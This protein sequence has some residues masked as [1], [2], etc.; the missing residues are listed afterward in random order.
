[1]SIKSPFGDV[2]IDAFQGITISAP[3]GNIKLEGKNVEII[4][5]NNL[6]ITSGTNIA[7]P[8]FYSHSSADYDENDKE[9]NSKNVADFFL[10]KHLLQPV[11]GAAMK[12]SVDLSL[13]RTW[14][15]SIFRPIGGTM[16][17]KSHSFMRLEAGKGQTAINSSKGSL[18]GN[19]KTETVVNFFKSSFRALGNYAFEE[20]GNVVPDNV[21]TSIIAVQ[22][23]IVDAYNKYTILWSSWNSLEQNIILD[24]YKA[25]YMQPYSKMLLVNNKGRDTTFFTKLKE[26]LRFKY[27]YGEEF[28]MILDENK[29]IHMKIPYS[30]EIISF[31]F[32][33]L[34]E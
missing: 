31:E 12:M 9:N 17:I 1:M 16:L 5:R 10:L 22:G 4:A 30:V 25:C 33:P 34:E 11:A 8:R 29:I 32:K 26:K 19:S 14:F 13:Y 7:N 23:K 24:F 21:W 6:S 2:S 15:E 28:D 3:S 27:H 20:K 18:K